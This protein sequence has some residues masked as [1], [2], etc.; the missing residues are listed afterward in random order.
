MSFLAIFGGFTMFCA[1]LLATE[2]SSKG[3]RVTVI[4]LIGAG[5]FGIGFVINSAGLDGMK[6]ASRSCQ[7]DDCPYEYRVERS[8]TRD[9]VLVQKWN[10]ANSWARL[11]S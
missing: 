5:I 10:R 8:T 11:P 7:F 9:T 2:S 6:K 3:Q 4:L 1:G